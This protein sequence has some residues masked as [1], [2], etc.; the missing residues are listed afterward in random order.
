MKNAKKL[1][2]VLLA[3]LTV[4]LL[5]APAFAAPDYSKYLTPDEAAASIRAQ[6]KERKAEV[7]V[8][9]ATTYKS[10]RAEREEILASPAKMALAAAKIFTQVT[11]EFVDIFAKALDHTGDPCEGDYIFYQYLG[12]VPHFDPLKIDW[13]RFVSEGIVGMSADFTLSYRT[14]AEQEAL[15]TE[16]I[17]KL[18]S[19]LGLKNAAKSTFD[20]VKTIYDWMRENITYDFDG[21]A[22]YLT[23][24][25]AS[26]AYAALFDGTAVCQ[27]YS[28]L[29]YRLCLEAGID[30]RVVQDVTGGGAPHVW[31]IVKMDDGKYYYIDTT[32]GAGF[33]QQL[34][35]S[36]DG[37]FLK[38][39]T[40]WSRL[41]LY[42]LGDQYTNKLL[43]PGFAQKFPISAG[44]YTAPEHVHS[45]R[46]V[47]AKAA[48]KTADGNTEYWICT[49]C[50]AMFSDAEGLHPILPDD[51]VIPATGGGSGFASIFADFFAKI[52]DFFRS[53]FPFC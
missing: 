39:S 46:H 50:N 31:N 41:P 4:L 17:A 12:F 1:L 43:Y 26:S 13:L 3:L 10:T 42:T 14:T 2:S 53:I 40:Y 51:T 45:L 19:S 32:L 47:P 7:S 34:G 15:V 36:A 27:G 29:F 16:K 6:M 48:T 44:D 28:V 18:S 22:N 11:E 33:E 35:L 49:D 23:K 21:L 8:W 24:P 37:F 30:A 20:K 9:Y 38:G 52:M 5:S 25:L